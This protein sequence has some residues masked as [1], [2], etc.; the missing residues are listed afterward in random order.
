MTRTLP[1]NTDQSITLLLTSEATNEPLTGVVFGDITLHYR[2]KGGTLTSYTVTSSNFRELDAT[3]APGLYEI[4]LDAGILDVPGSFLLYLLENGGA[5]LNHVFLEFEVTPTQDTPVIF[6]GSNIPLDVAQDM[7][8]YVEASSN[9]L[10]GLSS[11]LVTSTLFKKGVVTAN[12]IGSSLIEIDA[13]NQ[14]GWYRYTLTSSHVDTEGDLVVDFEL[15]GSSKSFT[16]QSSGLTV[17]VLGSSNTGYKVY[18]KDSLTLHM[19]AIADNDGISAPSGVRSTDGGSTWTNVSAGSSGDI[20]TQGLPGSDFVAYGGEDSGS[21][22]LNYSDDNGSTFNKATESSFTVFDP[23]LDI[24]VVSS[25]LAFAVAGLYTL[26]WDR[27]ADSAVLAVVLS[28]GGLGGGTEEA[29]A[30]HALDVSIAVVLYKDGSDALI[31][32]TVNGGSTWANV[33]VPDT[34]LIYRD[35]DFVPG[36]TTG[37][38]VGDTGRILK[39]TDSGASFSVQTSGTTAQLQGVLALSDMIAWVAG[40]GVLLYTTNGGVTWTDMV[41]TLGIPAS[42]ESVNLDG[43]LNGPLWI[44]GTTSA[45]ETFVYKIES[46]V[47]ESARVT[48][49]FFVVDR[50][51]SGDVT[52]VSDSLDDLKGAGFDSVTDSLVQVVSNLNTVD[53]AL[54]EIQGSGFDDSTDSLEQIRNNLGGGGSSDLTP[55][56]TA[57][58]TLQGDVDVIQDSVGRLL[59]LAQENYRI[60][61]QSYNANNKLTSASIKI[62]A[63]KANADANTSPTAQYL[64]TATYDGQG[65]LVDYLV[66]RES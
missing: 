2:K 17:E 28:P 58:S 43:I 42:S 39:S 7:A 11:S 46:V 64:L 33:T 45:P 8:L 1:Q 40:V 52:L 57:L 15:G 24:S 66:T 44:V 20:A 60:T 62:F 27:V 3:N 54:T 4:D 59:G 6:E 37:W 26:K 23:I 61:G 10:T 5:D 36:G 21:P 22:D 31:G 56:L 19:T 55:V 34:G 51:T 14:P 32:R 50:V 25:N 63:D 18:A 41:S 13:I 30:I 49:R 12:A 38:I 48:H 9:P 47:S 53:T 16:D 65:L 29:V 35:V